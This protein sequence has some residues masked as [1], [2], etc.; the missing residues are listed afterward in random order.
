MDT[1]AL[2]LAGA[3]GIDEFQAESTLSMCLNALHSIAGILCIKPL[4][5]YPDRLTKD[6]FYALTDKL[7]D[8]RLSAGDGQTWSRPIPR[9]RHL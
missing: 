5:T 7:R 6:R 4:A 1:C 8:C 9:S 2:R 3:V